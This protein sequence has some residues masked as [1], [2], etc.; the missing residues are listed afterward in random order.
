MATSR[1]IRLQVMAQA[2]L[3]LNVRL[4]INGASVVG[5]R[6]CVNEVAF[7]IVTVLSRAVGPIVVDEPG[8]FGVNQDR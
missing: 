3:I 4:I 5:L 2:R 6:D 8:V 1:I 7:L